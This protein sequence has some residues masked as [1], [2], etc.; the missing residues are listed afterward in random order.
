MLCVMLYDSY[1]LTHSIFISIFFIYIQHFMTR[2][3]IHRMLNTFVAN[4]I[5][6]R[7]NRHDILTMEV[8]NT[9]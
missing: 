1:K 6:G 9:K 3:K 5:K 2:T 4:E 7:G 8:E